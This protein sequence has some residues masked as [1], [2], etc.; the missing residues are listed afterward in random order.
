VKLQPTGANDHAVDQGH[1]ELAAAL[2]RQGFE[3][4]DHCLAVGFHGSAPGCSGLVLGDAD[5][6]PV[7][8]GLEGL[9]ARGNLCHLGAHNRRVLELFPK[10]QVEELL[11]LPVQGDD[12]AGHVGRG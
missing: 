2:W 6:E 5:T 8:S 11:F 9:P 12:L 7:R 3:P 10:V 1:E 4:L